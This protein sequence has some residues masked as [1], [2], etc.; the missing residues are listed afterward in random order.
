YPEQVAAML[1]STIK[2]RAEDFTSKRVAGAVV[3]VP[4]AYNRTQRQALRDACS[5][6]GLHVQRLVISSTASAVASAESLGDKNEN[7][8]IIS[9]KTV[10]MVDCGGGSLDVTLARLGFDRIHVEAT[11]GNLETG[12]EALTDRL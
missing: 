1:L 4:A 11:A 8:V 12:G 3:S 7:G 10:V 5:I 2:Q 9:K 6:A